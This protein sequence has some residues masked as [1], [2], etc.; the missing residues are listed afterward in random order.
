M[1]EPFVAPK[2]T[3]DETPQ[4]SIGDKVSCTQTI[5]K[6]TYGPYN[7]TIDKILPA[8]KGGIIRVTGLAQDNKR[9]TAPQK[10]CTKTG[11]GTIPAPPPPPIPG[12]APGSI[13]AATAPTGP[14]VPLTTATPGSAPGDMPYEELERRMLAMPPGVAPVT[15]TGPVPPIPTPEVVPPIEESRQ[16]LIEM[17]KQFEQLDGPVTPP[18]SPPPEP[19]APVNPVPTL[20]IAAPPGKTKSEIPGLTVY[21]AKLG[22]GAPE[23]WDWVVVPEINGLIL[24]D[25]MN[26]TKA[27]EIALNL[28]F[29]NSGRIFYLAPNDN[30]VSIEYLDPAFIISRT[31]KD[32]PSLKPMFSGGGKTYRRRK[33]NK[34]TRKAKKY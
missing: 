25:L 21:T 4:F 17:R 13:P 12:P 32:F 27:G 29:P 18:G 11:T 31:L 15:P 1:S 26:K 33:K 14:V 28:T 5:G 23:G 3:K 19:A 16:K 2:E 30:L 34:K 20:P 9:H 10:I 6:T 22:T 7:F 24:K 8:D